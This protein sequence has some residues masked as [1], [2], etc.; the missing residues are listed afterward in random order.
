VLHRVL[1]DAVLVAH[2]AFVAFAVAGALLALRW[3][4]APLVHL[5]AVLWGVYI[6][7]SGGVCPLTPLESS[8]RR[9]AGGSG[10]DGS[11]VEHHLVPI[12]YPSDLSVPL[13]WALAGGLVLAN[14]L[15]YTGVLL[16]RRGRDRVSC[17]RNESEETGP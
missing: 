2:F 17:A 9:A 14:A 8:L 3:R 4:W 15:L 10:Y 12:L 1:A 6:E 13:Q 11:F 16:R 5:P 7:L